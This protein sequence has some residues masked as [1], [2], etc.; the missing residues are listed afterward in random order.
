M[1]YKCTQN[2]QEYLYQKL[3]KS[4]NC[5]SSYSQKCRGWFLTHCEYTFSARRSFRCYQYPSLS[6]YIFTLPTVFCCHR[7]RH[8]PWSYLNKVACSTGIQLV[9]LLST[10]GRCKPICLWSAVNGGYKDRLLPSWLSRDAVFDSVPESVISLLITVYLGLDEW[11]YT[12][13]MCAI[14]SI[15][16]RLQ[17]SST[18][19][20]TLL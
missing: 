16:L 12:P 10:T 8:I 11:R 6:R 14:Y 4:F 15:W 5:F 9:Y 17:R 18:L 1:K 3:P 19:R 13:S 7:N 20:A 2:Q